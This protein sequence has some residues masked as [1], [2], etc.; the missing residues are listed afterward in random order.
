MEHRGNCMDCGISVSSEFDDFFFLCD[1]CA[2]ERMYQKEMRKQHDSD[3]FDDQYDNDSDFRNFV[4]SV[5]E[6]QGW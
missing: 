1:S 2:E 6:E 4:D 3:A 5:R